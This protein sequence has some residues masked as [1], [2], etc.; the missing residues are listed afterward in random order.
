[1]RAT[2]KSNCWRGLIM[3]GMIVIPTWAAGVVTGEEEP[4]DFA[5]TVPKPGTEFK[6][7]APIT[8]KGVHRLRIDDHVWIFLLDSFGGY[9]LQNPPVD[10]LSHGKWEAT[11]IRPRK[12]IRAIV[13]VFVGPKG[14]ERIRKWVEV[15][16]WGKISASEVKELPKY[17]ELARVP[18]VT[19]PPD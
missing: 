6:T 13:A 11:N 16:R 17:R 15:G 4:A 14:D 3:A 2:T 10:L 19:P 8:A 7:P 5:F 18:I 9:Y 12:G 1:M